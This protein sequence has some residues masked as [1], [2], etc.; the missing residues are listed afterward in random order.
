MFAETAAE[1]NEFRRRGFHE[2]TKKQVY[3]QGAAHSSF[4]WPAGPAAAAAAAVPLPDDEGMAPMPDDDEEEVPL[5]ERPPPEEIHTPYD[6]IPEIRKSGDG[7][8][9]EKWIECF[10]EKVVCERL[11]DVYSPIRLWERK[12]YAKKSTLNVRLLQYYFAKQN[13]ST[14]GKKETQINVKKVARDHARE[15]YGNDKKFTSGNGDLKYFDI[16]LHLYEGSSGSSA[17]AGDN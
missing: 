4:P 13:L 5:C 8:E 9:R 7:S 6:Y 14:D 3:H 12:E 15:K 16:C 17:G 1:A 2:F 10:E 11:K